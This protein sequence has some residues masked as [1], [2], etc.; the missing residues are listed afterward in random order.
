ML[1]AALP[2]ARLADAQHERRGEDCLLLDL[3]SFA[4]DGFAAPEV[5]IC[6]CDAVQALVAALVVVVIDEGPHLAFEIAG[7]VVVFW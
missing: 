1:Q 2:I 7:Q 6:G 4:E 3:F 5:D